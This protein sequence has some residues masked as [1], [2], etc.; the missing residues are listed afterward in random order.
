MYH[1]RYEDDDEEDL[2]EADLDEVAIRI[3]DVSGNLLPQIRSVRY[4]LG[5]EVRRFHRF[6][7][8]KRWK[9]GRI[10]SNA[11]TTYRVRYSDDGSQEDYAL[12][13]PE[14]DAMIDNASAVRCKL[15]K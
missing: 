2:E 14:V 5:S 15:K 9:I 4:P 8:E 11:P 12:G 3:P 6:G 13:D 7:D 1:I 10:V